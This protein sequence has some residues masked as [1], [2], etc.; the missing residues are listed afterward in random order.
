M[1]RSPRGH[2]TKTDDVR[3]R[4]ASVS[5]S[6]LNSSTFCVAS[7]QENAPPACARPPAAVASH[8][9]QLKRA[10]MFRKPRSSGSTASKVT[11]PLSDFSLSWMRGGVFHRDRFLRSI[12]K[13]GVV[14]SVSRVTTV[15]RQVGFCMRRLQ[16]SSGSRRVSEYLL[17]H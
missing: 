17:Q 4:K 5:P 10:R 16:S 1:P 12:W 14:H 3:V 13:L 7:H 11:A 9:L 15:V 6:A 8:V 2:R